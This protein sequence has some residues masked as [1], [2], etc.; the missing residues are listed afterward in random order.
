MSNYYEIL[1]IGQEASSLDIKNAFRKLAK[2]YHPDKNPT[3]K[4]HFEAILRAYEVLSDPVQRSTYDYRIKY[5]FQQPDKPI[6]K[7]NK[8]KNWNF[9][10]K[11]LKRRKYYDDYIKKYAK[12]TTNEQRVNETPKSNYNEFRYIL[13]ATPLAVVLFLLVVNLTSTNSA[14]QL[15]EEEATKIM[16][17]IKCNK[18]K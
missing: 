5:H 2:K 4:E 17:S 10:E 11:E 9:D 1:G 6:P 8:T 16:D 14:S 13:F 3:G 15:Q 12:A 18:T 7:R